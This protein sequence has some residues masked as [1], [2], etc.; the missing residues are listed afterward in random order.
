MAASSFVAVA[1][2]STQP[3]DL[4]NDWLTNHPGDFRKT[5]GGIDVAIR[6][7]SYNCNGYHFI[8]RIVW[9]PDHRA[10]GIGSSF[11]D[12]HDHTWYTETNKKLCI[13]RLEATVSE[14]YNQVSKIQKNT[15]FPIKC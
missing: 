3:P 6:D 11:D 4:L 1:A 12:W 15:F 9:S 5:L 14:I 13:R 10:D 8:L 2:S 7:E